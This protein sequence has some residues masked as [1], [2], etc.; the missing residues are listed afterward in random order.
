LK[1]KGVAS[2]SPIATAIKSSC[3]WFLRFAFPARSGRGGSLITPA[4]EVGGPRLAGSAGEVI[5]QA[6]K[7]LWSADLNMVYLR[8]I[9]F[10][11]DQ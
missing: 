8:F 2:L 7:M 4:G 5:W 10:Q 3:L 1:A 11:F 9:P 6:H